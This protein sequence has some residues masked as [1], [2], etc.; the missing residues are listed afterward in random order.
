[1]GM[2]V[3][4]TAQLAAVPDNALLALEVR[5]DGPERTQTA[6][7]AAAAL[8]G[9]LGARLPAVE[10]KELEGTLAAWAQTRGDFLTVAVVGAVTRG[11]LL[12]AKV[13]DEVQA[14]KAFD[15]LVRRLDHAGIRD[16][17][18]GLLGFKSLRIAP[19]SVPGVGAGTLGTLERDAAGPHAVLPGKLGI[20]WSA[21]RGDLVALAAEDAP[22]LAPSLFVPL[23]TLGEDPRV[24]DALGRVG[25]D[26]SIIG[27]L[28]P[29]LSAAS[30]RSDSAV[31][32]LGRRGDRAMLRVEA[33][34]AFV[35]EAM[36]RAGSGG[37]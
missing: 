24:H 15:A 31:F 9:V 32:A 21:Q 5:S 10:A 17:G 16:L 30:P 33:S 8:E 22:G 26:G 3:G 18:Q 28:R 20:F 25:Q 1:M 19:Q 37:F 36:R 14:A 4:D 13:S 35:R 23:R 2:H 6:K 11:L 12:R 7:D 27:V 29:F 34:G